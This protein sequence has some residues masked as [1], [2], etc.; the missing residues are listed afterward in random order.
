MISILRAAVLGVPLANNIAIGAGLNPFVFRL[1]WM[2]ASSN[3][4][5]RVADSLCADSVMFVQFQ[6]VTLSTLNLLY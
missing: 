6:L 2:L 3:S 5:H 4:D 1:T